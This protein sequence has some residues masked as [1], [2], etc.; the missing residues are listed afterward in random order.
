M[1]AID[2]FARQVAPRGWRVVGLAADN[3]APVREFLAVRPV[4]YPVGLTG[5][6]GIE[7]S[8]ALGNDAGGLPFT[9]LFGR[10]GRLLERHSGELS[11]EQLTAWANRVIT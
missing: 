3:I 4:S 7:L 8:K 11:A 6:A 2:R 1:P 9:L 10:G 5:F